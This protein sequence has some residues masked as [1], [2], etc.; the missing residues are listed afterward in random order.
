MWDVI[1][2]TLKKY[3]NLDDYTHDPLSIQLLQSR[4]M[5]EQIEGKYEISED[6]AKQYIE[7]AETDILQQTAKYQQEI[8]SLKQDKENIDK[9][10]NREKKKNID[11]QNQLKDIVSFI[12]GILEYIIGLIGLVLLYILCFTSLICQDLSID[13]VFIQLEKFS[14]EG[15]FVLNIAWVIIFVFYLKGKIKYLL[16]KQILNHLSRKSYVG[17][18]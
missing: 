11:S 16:E 9:E 10:L 4:S 17:T 3:K 1:I 18:K 8:D 2:N 5:L 6:E 12:S 7:K 15:R 13:L 14:F